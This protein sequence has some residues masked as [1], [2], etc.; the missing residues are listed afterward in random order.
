VEGSACEIKEVD[1]IASP[2]KQKIKSDKD[3]KKADPSSVPPY[4]RTWKQ[5][6]HAAIGLLQ[7]WTSSSEKKLYLKLVLRHN[8]MR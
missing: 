6:G 8:G 2:P 1:D 7:G 4:G 5:V 3:N